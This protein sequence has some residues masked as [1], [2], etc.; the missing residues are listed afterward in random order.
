MRGED[1]K[2][3][4]DE[5]RELR[6]GEIQ[7]VAGGGITSGGFGPGGALANHMAC[8][9]WYQFYPSWQENWTCVLF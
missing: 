1:C 7:N 4:C 3:T 9:V 5:M 6:A 8:D 2:L